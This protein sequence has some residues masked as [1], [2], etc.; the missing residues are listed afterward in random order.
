M[1]P[2]QLAREAARELDEAAARYEEKQPGLADRFLNELEEVIAYIRRHPS[3][4]PRVRGIP[5]EL[6]IRQRSFSRFPYLLIFMD[7]GSEIRGLAVCH[8]RRR[9]GYW[10]RRVS[11]SPL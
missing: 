8:V 9:P 4:S 6:N 10:L 2:F 11:P 1:K 7:L 5:P 3:A